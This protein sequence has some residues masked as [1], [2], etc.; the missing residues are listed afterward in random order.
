MQ[1]VIVMIYQDILDFHRSTLKFF[2]ARCKSL[3][4]ENNFTARLIRVV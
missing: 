4:N 2:R 3:E 1:E